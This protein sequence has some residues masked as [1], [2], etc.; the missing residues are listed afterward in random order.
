MTYRLHH[1]GAVGGQDDAIKVRWTA[2]LKLRTPVLTLAGFRN[3]IVIDGVSVYELD[4]EGKI[5][6]HVLEDIVTTPPS[7]ELAHPLD[8]IGV[9]WPRRQVA[10]ELAMHFRTLDRSEEKLLANRFDFGAG[11]ANDECES[12]SPLTEIAPAHAD[13]EETPMQRAARERE[14]DA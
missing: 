12:P 13:T 14:E 5:I 9:V 6:K 8:L 11:P 3:N 2:K 10:P 1:Q 7:D 4:A